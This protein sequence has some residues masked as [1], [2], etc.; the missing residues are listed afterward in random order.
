MESGDVGRPIDAAA[1]GMAA[2]QIARGVRDG[3]GIL[4]EARLNTSS[5]F[6]ALPDGE[7]FHCAVREDKISQVSCLCVREIRP[8]VVGGS[9]NTKVSVAVLFKR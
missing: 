2:F 4:I 5:E 1:W 3:A 7:G 9:P 6:V 8:K